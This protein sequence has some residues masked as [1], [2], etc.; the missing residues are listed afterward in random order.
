L[1]QGIFQGVNFF[2]GLGEAGA[3]GFELGQ[4]A[5]HLVFEVVKGL[6]AVEYP[7]RFLGEHFS[8]IFAGAATGGIGGEPVDLVPFVLGETEVEPAESEFF[9]FFREEGLP[10]LAAQ[11][12]SGPELVAG[13]RLWDDLKSV[14]QP[15]LYEKME[16]RIFQYDTPY[17]PLAWYVR[18]KFPDGPF[19]LP[20]FEWIK[21][22]AEIEIFLDSIRWG[23]GFEKVIRAIFNLFKA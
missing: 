1:F 22:Q 12:E 17:I 14:L 21:E 13:I 23:Q 2:V 5:Y 16:E 7:D 3:K 20:R 18:E 6:V 8:G 10:G 4:E 19:C 9:D 15:E 11:M